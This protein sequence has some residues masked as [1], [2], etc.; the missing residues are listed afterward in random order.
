MGTAAWLLATAWLQPPILHLQLA[1]VGVRAFAIGRA[2]LRYLERLVSHDAAFEGLTEERLAL[3]DRLRPLLPEGVR[4]RSGALLATLVGD[5]ERLQDRPLRAVGP[6]VTA[7]ACVVAT[8]A[9]VAWILPAAGVV[10]AATL[11]VSGAASVLVTLRVAARAERE[12]AP[13]AAL[14]DE[15]ILDLVRTRDLLVAYEAWDAAAARVVADD[16]A[17]ATRTRRL[18][19][20]AGAG[21]AIVLAAGGIAVAVTV[22][23]ADGTPLEP[24]LM[25]LVALVPLALFEVWAAVPQAIVTLRSVRERRARIAALAEG[26]AP[27][28]VGDRTVPVGA[29]RL[30]G[31][32]VRRSGTTVPFAPVD[33][34]A[35][36]GETVL[37]R[38]D[39]G[40]GKSSLAAALVRFVDAT[41]SMTLGGV[42]LAS[43]HP[44]SVREAIVLV[45]Q[46]PHLLDTSLRENLRVARED[47][48]DDDLWRALARVG[49]D[50]WARRRDGLDTTMGD[51]ASLVSGGEAQR[52]ALARALLS[53]ASVLVLDE[54]TAN[55]DEERAEVLVRDLLVA[56]SAEGRIVVVTSHM[57]LPDELVTSQVRLQPTGVDAA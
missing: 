32:Q 26:S 17:L 13:L 11:V 20:A 18:A 44:E 35:Q 15:R 2:A 36:P 6:L 31:V 43:L 16:A 28:E 40:V 1:I 19:V 9:V 14:L 48:S 8:V 41:G 38:G 23:I 37:V 54:P 27:A 39:S 53:E 51:R 49:L 29:L 4:R 46:L 55:V 22:A 56:A 52:I 21:N 10:L 33:L 24:G 42:E 5:V 3:F 45:E 12:V 57:P 50:D 47:A 7:A 30:R 25:A 34:D